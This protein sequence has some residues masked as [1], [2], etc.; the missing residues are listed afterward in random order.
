MERDR[1]RD[2]DRERQ[3]KREIESKKDKE[4]EQKRD[5]ERERQKVKEKDRGRACVR[6]I[7]IARE[8]ELE[9]VCVCE[10]E[11]HCVCSCETVRCRVSL[12]CQIRN[13]RTWEGCSTPMGRCCCQAAHGHRPRHSSVCF[14]PRRPSK[15]FSWRSAL[16]RRPLLRRV[17]CAK[18][19]ASRYL[20]TGLR[21][22]VHSIAPL[23]S[24]R[25]C[26]SW[27]MPVFSDINRW[28]NTSSA[29]VRP[30]RLGRCERRCTAH[31][32]CSLRCCRSWQETNVSPAW[33]LFVWSMLR[34]ADQCRLGSSCVRLSPAHIS[35]WRVGGVW[36][37][38]WWWVVGHAQAKCRGVWAKGRGVWAKKA[39]AC[40]PPHTEPSCLPRLSWYTS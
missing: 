24:R 16:H 6:K 21:C 7:E 30:W 14:S 34:T 3:K 32:R 17:L 28:K 1:E 19:V 12:E 4:S 9:R 2:R 8:R 29:R 10:R 38:G 35:V 5:R 37:G 22:K 36:G 11:T 33:P 27:V 40:P 20:A 18:V 31:P 39:G 15:R 25:A 13:P 26:S 23:W